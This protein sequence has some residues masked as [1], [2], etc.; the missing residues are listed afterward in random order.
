[1]KNLDGG[2]VIFG[3]GPVEIRIGRQF[4]LLCCGILSDEKRRYGW[5]FKKKERLVRAGA[6]ILI[7]DF[8]H[9]EVLLN[10]LPLI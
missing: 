4:G 6:H 5:D 10:E 9:Y 3:D 1:M 2:A 7:P 8:S